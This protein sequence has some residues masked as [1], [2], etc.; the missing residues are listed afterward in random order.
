MKK[1]LIKVYG[2]RNTG[3]NYLA[4]LID[5]NFQVQQLPGT[6]PAWLSKI[7]QLIHGKEFARDA[8]FAMTYHSNLGWKHSRV[9]SAEDIRKCAVH[10]KDLSF[11]TLTKNPYSWLLSMY[12]RPYHRYFHEKPDF[13]TFL[14][15]P[16]GCVGRENVAGVIS[17]P[18]ELWN[19]KNASYIQLVN[20]LPALTLRFEDLLEDPKHV[21]ESISE[22]FSCKW[23]VDRFV[24]FD[25]ST[26]ESGKDSD[27]YRDY[28]LNEQWKAEFSPQLTTIIN[29]HLN[30]DV[31][32][33]FN[34]QKWGA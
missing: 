14:S 15:N 4:R 29:K 13:E 21:L 24:N 2:E 27:F 18:V 34:Y 23:K 1:Q 10:T 31:M 7:Q 11:I 8:Y 30:D 26:K 25:Q 22:A 16:W 17:N 5:L 3:T 6:I 28:Y 12:R 33:Y 19:I 32:N 9:K 20:K